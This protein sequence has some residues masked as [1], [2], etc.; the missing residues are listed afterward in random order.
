MEQKIHN[1]FTRMEEEIAKFDKVFAKG[2][3]FEQ[4]VAQNN[5]D[6]AWFSDIRSALDT[7][8]NALME[9]H[10]AA[11]PEMEEDVNEGRLGFSDIEKFGADAASKIDNECRRRGSADM[12]PGEADELRYKV[13]K[14]M[15]YLKES[16]LTEGVLDADDDD[17]FMARSQ[18]YFLA[19]DAI[20]LHGVI[21]DRDNLEGWVQSKIAQSAEAIDAVR[22]YTEYNAL[23][24]DTAP[25]VQPEME[26]AVYEDPSKP[27]F[28]VKVKLA[29]N[30]IWDR[31]NKNP[32]FVT[33]TGYH[34]NK[35]EDD[36]TG[37]VHVTVN[38]DGPWTIYTDSGFEEAISNMI[39]I[40]V[41]FTEQGMQEDGR[42]SLEGHTDAQESVAEGKY[43]NDAQRK[44]VHAAKAEKKTEAVAESEERPY[45]CVHAKKGKHECHAK[46]SY[47]A[48]KKAAE[49]WKM[50]STAG[51]DA[52]LAD[53]EKVAEEVKFDE[54][55]TVDLKTVAQ[56]MFKEFKSKA[57]KK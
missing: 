11:M 6:I 48:A 34:I 3:K 17:G 35:E 19:R 43:K 57:G 5:G 2:G 50:K 51:I 52:H 37:Y 32:E 10:Q 4:A 7:L 13:A 28:P 49:H 14:E 21:N 42:A 39:G 55:R 1:T 41:D 31:E 25:D 29:G 22:R 36:D 45:M 47:E 46:S 12:S 40:D 20:T 24:T 53:K 38:H 56:D 15:G 54:K 30:S 44:A 18:L 9:G 8:A 33:V 16:K 27:N 26:Q 23:K